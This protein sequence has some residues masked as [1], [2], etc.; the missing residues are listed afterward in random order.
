[1]TIEYR[2]N[3]VLWERGTSPVGHTG[4]TVP[5]AKLCE[6]PEECLISIITGNGMPIDFDEAQ[7]FEMCQAGAAHFGKKL[8]ITDLPTP[9]P[10]CGGT[11]FDYVY[12]PTGRKLSKHCES[13]DLS[14]PS[15]DDHDGADEAWNVFF[16]PTKH[17]PNNPSPISISEELDRR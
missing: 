15:A 3:K 2:R 12:G 10:N 7:F 1:M 8:T 9:C 5:V 14:G 11:V 6:G 4:R 16:H 13:C 17:S